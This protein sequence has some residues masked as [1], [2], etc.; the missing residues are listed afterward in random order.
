M[1]DQIASEAHAALTD[2][3]REPIHVPEAIQPHGLLFVLD[4][5]DLRI[6]REAG[7]MTSLTSRASWLGCAVHEFLGDTLGKRLKALASV[8]QG[9]AG[10]WRAANGL[11]YDV[12][13]RPNAAGLVLEVEQSSQGA[14]L[15]VELISR[16][17]AAAA[18]LERAGSLR[19]VC[20]RAA[21][22]FRALTGYDRV[23]IYRF[24]GEHSDENKNA[25]QYGRSRPVS[26]PHPGRGGLTS[27]KCCPDT[28]SAARRRSPRAAPAP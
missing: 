28:S 24:L 2:C 26:S 16:L 27:R 11:D 10:R 3:D 7:R 5:D 25:S 15:G 14:Q 1:T 23:M 6:V 18:A 20:E 19:A 13:V 21:E 12:T 4:R 8:E 22:A 9:F 17:D